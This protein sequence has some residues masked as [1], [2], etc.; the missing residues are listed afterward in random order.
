MDIQ[1]EVPEA[2]KQLRGL[3]GEFQ[4]IK[5]IALQL[6][7]KNAY[8]EGRVNELTKV[9]PAEVRSFAD[10]L[11]S[12]RGNKG[13]D[14]EKPTTSSERK[15]VL[16][17]RTPEDEQETSPGE[18]RE[19]L[20]KHFDPITLGLKDVGI[21]PIRGGVAVTTTSATAIRTLKD[22]LM[23]HDQTKKF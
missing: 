21:R 12:N 4:S 20:V 19:K 16:L 18:V 2:S 8:L 14:R 6:V 7:E 9:K 17:V 23:E 10:I 22:K 1:Q 13:Q 11:R 5:A 15:A 3:L